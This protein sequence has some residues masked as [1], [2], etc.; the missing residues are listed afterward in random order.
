ML[1][2]YRS[3]AIYLTFLNFILL[4]QSQAQTKEYLA[5][6][7]AFHSRQQMG[8]TESSLQLRHQRFVLFVYPNAVAVYSESDFINQGDELFT[9]EFAIPST[10]HD[11]NGSDPGGRISNGILSIQLW[12]QGERADPEF[13]Q[14][15]NEEWY[16][17]QTTFAP[18]EERKV[19]A[20]FWAETSLTDIDSLLGSDTTIIANGKRGFLI[21]LSHAS[22]WNNN[23]ESNDVVVVLKDGILSREQN[24]NAEPKTYDL[25]DS[26]LTW[27]QKYVEPSLEDNIFIS[28]DSP[29]NLDLN[30]ST[31]AKLA[32]YIVKK[33]YDQLLYFVSQLNEL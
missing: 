27:S 20:L 10:G 29:A 28:Y 17:I 32:D 9:Q 33:V 25:K 14:E 6:I 4:N 23:I 26:T 31:M 18:N 21:D 7:P 24:F 16:T 30:M 5:I 12:I 1:N 15:G 11:E 8:S 22:I 2:I 19:K 3:W 13:I